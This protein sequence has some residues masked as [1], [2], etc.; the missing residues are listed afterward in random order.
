MPLPQACHVGRWSLPPAIDRSRR[1]VAVPHANVC[2][3]NRPNLTQSTNK[4][5]SA[6]LLLEKAS[7]GIVIVV[8]VVFTPNIQRHIT[9]EPT[10]VPTGSVREVLN[11]IFEEN[12]AARG[13]VLDDRGAVRKHMNI[14][15]NGEPIQDRAT[16]GDVV[17]EGAEV[18][19][20]Q[21]LSGG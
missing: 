13:Y 9:C 2:D 8:R 11:A 4:I 17:P 7:P 19:V 18:Y 21:A 14:F 6:G 15:I 16:L 10:T 1:R 20:M 3:V 12:G 5:G